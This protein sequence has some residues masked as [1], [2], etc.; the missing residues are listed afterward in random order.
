MNNFKNLVNYRI[1]SLFLYFVF[2][3]LG[4][5]ANK[6]I[7]RLLNQYIF[8]PSLIK[9]VLKPLW[10]SHPHQDVRVCLVLTLLHFVGKSNSNDDQT[11]IWNILEEAAHDDYLLVIEYLFSAHRGDSRWPLTH[12]KNSSDPIFKTYVNQIQ[13]KVLDHPTSLQARS[14]AWLNIDYEHCDTNKLIEKAQQLCIQFNKDANNLW[15]SA[16]QKI[17]SLYKLN[18]M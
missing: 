11:T 13:F 14:S 10:D 2:F 1:I 3:D 8:D 16:F 18:K 7:L 12:L 6:E 15:T 17:I 4:I 9:T 5:T